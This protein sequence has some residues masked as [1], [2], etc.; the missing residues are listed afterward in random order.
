MKDAQEDMARAAMVNLINRLVGTG[1]DPVEV[2]AI[3]HAELV[4]QCI[5]LVGYAMVAEMLQVCAGVVRVQGDGYP[6][7]HHDLA[8]MPT[9][10]RA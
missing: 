10:G 8:T 4:A 2:L 5:P 3:L 7:G 1:L 6:S 9:V